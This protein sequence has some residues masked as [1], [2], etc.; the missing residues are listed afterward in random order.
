MKSILICLLLTGC[1]VQTEQDIR[2]DDIVNSAPG[3]D[4]SQK[5]G[6]GIDYCNDPSTIVIDGKEFVVQA[7]CEHNI[8]VDKGDPDPMK[9]VIPNQQNI[10]SM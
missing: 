1:Y 2:P 7:L 9:A 3:S 4:V 6:E 8:V 5:I 10:E